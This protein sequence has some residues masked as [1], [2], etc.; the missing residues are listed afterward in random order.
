MVVRWL[1]ADNF[2]GL[3]SCNYFINKKLPL[4]GEFTR[5]ELGKREDE[6]KG[7]YS[8]WHRRFREGG[9]EDKTCDTCGC[10]DGAGRG[11][12]RMGFQ[13]WREMA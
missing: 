2:S 9:P 7:V 5:G 12:F 6:E 13:S 8:V 10:R 11:W 4:L 3:N 1:T